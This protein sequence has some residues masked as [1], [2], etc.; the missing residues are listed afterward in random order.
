VKRTRGRRRS[1]R[2]QLRPAPAACV[3][4]RRCWAAASRCAPASHLELDGFR[5]QSEAQRDLANLRLGWQGDNDRVT[6]APSTTSTSR[7]GPAGPDAEEQLD[8]DPYQTTPQALEF[9]TRKTAQQT[10]LGASWRH[11]FGDG[12]LRETRS[13][14]AYA[15]RR[16]ITQYLAIAP[17][18]RPRRGMA[19]A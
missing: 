7:P 14:R 11:R 1:R 3:G 4:G 19:A 15:G 8:A 6:R 9:D 17:A 10:Q 2:R 13:S 18:R 16:A 12:V 5:P